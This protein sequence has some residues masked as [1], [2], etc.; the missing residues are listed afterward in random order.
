M[1]KF[2]LP[3]LVCHIFLFLSIMSISTDWCLFC[4]SICLFLCLYVSVWLNFLCLALSVIYIFHGLSIWFCLSFYVYL[5]VSVFFVY[6][7]VSVHLSFSSIMRI[8]LLPSLS[9]LPHTKTHPCIISAPVARHQLTFRWPEGLKYTPSLLTGQHTCQ[10]RHLSHAHLPPPLPAFPSHLFHQLSVFFFFP[11]RPSSSISHL[12]LSGFPSHSFSL[13]SILIFFFLFC[14]LRPFSI[15][16]LNLPAL[17]SL[18]S[19]FFLLC[20]LPSPVLL[21]L[22]TDFVVSLLPPSFSLPFLLFLYFF[23]FPLARFLS[24]SSS[25]LYVPWFYFL[26]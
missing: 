11:L 16:R 26:L 2:A 7:S 5:S 6:L 25:N 24:L 10:G 17:C 19:L 23:F 20:F 1:S 3:Y 4:L 18:P 13:H 9:S 8:C 21:N 12:H 14:L 22:F 15:F